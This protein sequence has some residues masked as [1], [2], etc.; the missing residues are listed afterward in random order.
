MEVGGRCEVPPT[1]EGAP[2]CKVGNVAPNEPIEPIE[3]VLGSDGPH[4]TLN[5]PRCTF[6]PEPVRAYAFCLVVDK[7]HESVT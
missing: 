7:L 4:E 1:F 6:R 5:S 2:T 3:Q